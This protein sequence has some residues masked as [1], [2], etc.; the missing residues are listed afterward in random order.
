MP[1]HFLLWKEYY[2]F[3]T[4]TTPSSLTSGI[5]LSLYDMK[6]FF[7]EYPSRM[8]CNNYHFQMV[9][10]VNMLFKKYK[11][12]SPTWS[13]PNWSSRI[14]SHWWQII[15]CPFVTNT[16]TSSTRSHSI[17]HHWHLSLTRKFELFIISIPF[18]KLN[19]VLPKF[20]SSPSSEL[21]LLYKS[22]CFIITNLTN[23]T[24]DFV[25]IIEILIT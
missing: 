2:F 22:I 1:L 19:R 3:F 16:P 11:M 24:I 12:H 23:P 21:Y 13:S 10:I 14:A 15:T 8:I 6:N 25:N 9:I 18:L 7:K 4:P 5:W 20:P 17:P